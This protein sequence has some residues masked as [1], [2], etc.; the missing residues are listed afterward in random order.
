VDL[1]A[2]NAKP[3]FEFIL[4]VVVPDLDF[5]APG[6]FPTASGPGLGDLVM[7]PALQFNPVKFSDNVQFSNRLE[8]EFLVPAGRYS[9]EHE[10]NPGAG[11]W[12]FDPYWA[13]TLSLGT[14]IKLSYRAHYLWNARN[15]NPDVKL[16]AD[17]TTAGQAFHINFAGAY[18]LL[19]RKLGEDEQH[20]LVGLNGYWL[21]QTTDAEI[22]GVPQP[23]TREQVL[24]IGPGMVY[25]PTK[26]TYFFVNLYFE[27]D[28][29][30]RPEGT[31]L[32][33]RY[34]KHF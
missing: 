10:I 3:L 15:N 8:A 34:I 13:G 6:P 22:N 31:R 4:P 20:L 5:S 9:N 28:V 27:T 30:N 21:K 29:R 12:S 7:G 1:P 26:G 11:F 33:L 2:L 32:T 19:D 14:K 18:D 23:D 24:G 17:S 25:S 16:G